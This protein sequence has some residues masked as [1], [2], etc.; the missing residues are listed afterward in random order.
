MFLC[1]PALSLQ[2]DAVTGKTGKHNGV[3]EGLICQSNTI[4]C[5]TVGTPNIQ[6]PLHREANLVC[7]SK[8]SWPI[9]LVTPLACEASHCP[10]WQPAD[11]REHGLVL[12]RT[13]TDKV[14][15]SVVIFIYDWKLKQL[16]KSSSITS[17]VQ[18]ILPAHIFSQNVFSVKGLLHSIFTCF[19]I[20][21]LVNFGDAGRFILLLGEGQAT[22]SPVSSLQA[23][24]T[25]CLL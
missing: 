22:C 6:V 21:K 2:A 24:L 7:G 8:W 17:A 18:S 19:Y 15:I 20:C 1:A 13:V 10:P 23:K 12:R 9:W 11:E 3:M 5:R 14:I 4:S 25:G 16:M